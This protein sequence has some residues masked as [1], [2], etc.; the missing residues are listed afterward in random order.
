MPLVKTLLVP[1]WETDAC[2]TAYAADFTDGGVGTQPSSA[3][4]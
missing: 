2:G 3:I 1:H 4:T